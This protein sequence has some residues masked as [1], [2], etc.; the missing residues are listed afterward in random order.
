MRRFGERSWVWGVTCFVVVGCA[1][2]GAPR[3]ARRGA[4]RGAKRTE[5]AMKTA[6]AVAVE[7]PVAPVVEEITSVEPDVQAVETVDEGDAL[8]PRVDFVKPLRDDPVGR[9]PGVYFFEDFE[10]IRNLKDRFQ[11]T[12]EGE[13]RFVVSGEDRMSGS[14][15]LGQTYRPRDSMKG[16]PGGAGWVSRFVG[17]SPIGASK[18]EDKRQQR[19]IWARWYHKFAEDFNAER[20]DGI[21][22]PPKHARLGCKAAGWKKVYSLLHWIGGK[23]GHI[24]I[25]RHTKAPGTHREWIPKCDTSFTFETPL[26]RG[27]WIHMEMALILGDAGRTDHVMA[28][29]DGRLICDIPN[30]DLVGGWKDLG[31]T[32]MMW[33]CYWNGGSPVPGNSRYY[34][35]LALSNRQAVGP[36]RTSGK[37][38]LVLCEGPRGARAVEVEV[39]FVTQKPLK[40]LKVYDK[41][42]GSYKPIELSGD[43]VWKGVVD[44]TAK[45][46]VVDAATG[47]FTGSLAGRDALEAN[48]M[49]MVRLRRQNGRGAWTPWTD[50]HAAFA[51]D[52]APGTAR[53]EKAPPRGML[54]GDVTR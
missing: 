35:D 27:R 49:Y 15:S 31:I 37:P 29:A 14:R 11:D 39:G 45:Q 7:K 20:E 44:G 34:D 23:D 48:T 1:G 42:P 32:Y 51:T 41:V 6:A 30:D 17:D 13:G 43:V 25:E 21:H 18:I 38:T 54:N 19:R 46:V 33:D 4:D 16:D 5:T 3:K 22:Y 8:P 52:W 24:V 40:P 50:W 10:S 36:V 9:A 28:W 53:D 2:G 47:A 12:S 26:N